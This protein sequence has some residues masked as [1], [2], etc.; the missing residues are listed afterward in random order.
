MAAII[1]GKNLLTDDELIEFAFSDENV[2]RQNLVQLRHAATDA[3]LQASLLLIRTM[4]ID[5]IYVQSATG[6][7]DRL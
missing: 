1:L 5:R 7:K 3:A 2:Q 6:S 4:R